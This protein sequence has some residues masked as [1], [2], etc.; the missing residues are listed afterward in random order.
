MPLG[1]YAERGLPCEL[2]GAVVFG[3]D[4]QLAHGRAHVRAGAA[5]E[6]VRRYPTTPPL[7]A[8]LF[9]PV[10]HASVPGLLADGYAVHALTPGA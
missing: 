10:G 7:S 3:A 8:R 2:C 6:L 5:V 9:L 1:R 4:G